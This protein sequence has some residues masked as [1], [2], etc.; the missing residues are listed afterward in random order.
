MNTPAIVWKF[1]DAPQELRDL[2]QNGGDEDWLVELP[3]G[4]DEY[5]LPFWC[6]AMDSM[7]EPQ[8]YDHPAKPEWQVVI[9]AHA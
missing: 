9:G 6:E 2:S 4:W 1:H 7:H 3:P 5:G 8:S